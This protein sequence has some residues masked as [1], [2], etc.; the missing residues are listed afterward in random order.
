[1]LHA[2]TGDNKQS[3]DAAHAPAAKEPERI[4]HS[5]YGQREPHHAA[6]SGGGEDLTGRM[7]SRGRRLPTQVQRTY[8]NQAVLRMLSHAPGAP[9]LQKLAVGEPH[10]HYEQEA[11]K[12][13]DVV[14]RM[15]E[16]G[17]QRKCSCGGDSGGEC[18]ECKKKKEEATL[19]RAATQPG[20]VSAAPRIVHEVLRSPGR[21]LEP[22]TRAFFEPRFGADFGHVRVH[23]DAQAADSV[24]AVHAH[25]YTVGRNVVFG[26]GRYAPEASGGRWLVAHE[27]AHVIQQHGARE[28]PLTPREVTG[29]EAVLEHEAD[30]SASQ[31]MTGQRAPVSARSSTAWLARFSESRDMPK[32]PDGSYVEVTRIV[33]PG[34]CAFGPGFHTSTSADIT[35]QQAYVEFDVCRGHVGV[36]TRGELD[37]GQALNGIAAATSRFLQ[38][39]LSAGQNA[40]QAGQ[41]LQN[42]LKQISPSA[43]IAIN[44]QAPGFR[45]N[46]TGTG[47]ASVAQ[48]A[49]GTATV[50]PEVDI[51]SVTVG[52][53]G[54]VSGGQHT[55]TTYL[56]TITIGP[57]APR[58]LPN[59]RKCSCGPPQVSFQCSQHKPPEKKPPP[60]KPLSPVT[61]ALFYSC[62]RTTAA[63]PDEYRRTL[64][65]T[66]DLISQGYTISRIEGQT[67]PEGP[68]AKQ[69][70]GTGGCAG[71][72]PFEGNIELA[73]HRA[74]TGWRDLQ[75]KIRARLSVGM[76][77]LLSLQDALGS[78]PPVVGGGEILGRTSKG[79]VPEGELYSHL[80][81]ASK[82][83]GPGQPSTLEQQVVVPNLPPTT[84]AEVS[85]G[86]KEF[87]TGRRGEQRLTRA[88]QLQ[89][90]YPTMR[91]ALIQLQP[92][93]PLPSIFI[94]SP[95]A[96]L[97]PILDIVR[98][99]GQSIDCTEDHRR[100]FAPSPIPASEM[101]EG[102]CREANPSSSREESKAA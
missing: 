31:A 102:E 72:G 10:D 45:L 86:V 36:Q 37:Y 54:S 24:R 6:T 27:L 51:G 91:R 3:K 67:S 95:V 12:A 62:G 15:A 16:P 65:D 52:V 92:P 8:G 71:G 43:T 88:A 17:L 46:I 42:D 90:L 78:P 4:L 76:R 64:D 34:H 57:R 14:M 1:M 59:C 101:F 75:E 5:P 80:Q 18:A 56:V 55:P 83:A 98:G 32:Q 2:P 35:S 26:A 39:V 13:A 50:G 44:L 100:L 81:E 74:D 73:K 70:T 20:A 94:Q 23:A 66:V 30:L 60:P 29:H 69:R 84:Q 99:L 77:G 85:A 19:Q 61:E 96:P 82:P 22:A 41:T 11:D 38:N 33:T 47:Q 28:T 97:F 53:K 40:N 49:S 89:D 9:A 7:G 48:G 63:S 87:E 58:T 68:E 93:T 79:E 21:P 25:A